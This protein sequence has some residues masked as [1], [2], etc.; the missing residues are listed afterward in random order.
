MRGQRSSIAGK[1]IDVVLVA[2][3][4]EPSGGRLQLARGHSRRGAVWGDLELFDRTR[5][6]EQLQSGR[7]L[8]TGRPRDLVGDFEILGQVSL[9]GGNGEPAALTVEGAA[10]DRDDLRLPLF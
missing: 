9:S 6:V 4:Y 1:K 10:T 8:A 5:L 3:R 2:V 7:R